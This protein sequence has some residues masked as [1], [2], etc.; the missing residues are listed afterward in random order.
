MPS[1][2]RNPPHVR[3]YEKPSPYIPWKPPGQSASKS[4]NNAEALVQKKSICIYAWKDAKGVKHYSNTGFPVNEA[5]TE[6]SI[7]WK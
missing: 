6:P 7:E 2:P 5:Y 3:L 1:P 4:A